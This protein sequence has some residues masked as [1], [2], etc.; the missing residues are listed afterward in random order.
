MSRVHVLLLL[1]CVVLPLSGAAQAPSPPPMVPAP[2]APPAEAVQP[3]GELIPRSSVTPDSGRGRAGRVILGPLTG[4]VLG[5]LAA[6]PGLVL[7]GDSFSCSTCAN[8]SE[9]IGGGLVSLVGFTAGTALGVKLIGSLFWG[10]GRFLKTLLGSALGFGGGLLTMIPLIETEGGWAVPLIIGPL[11]GA[12][13]GYELSHTEEL[14]RMAAGPS[15]AVLPS[16]SV[17][18]SGGVIAGLMGRF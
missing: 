15:V 12:V 3:E 17:H 11:I 2:A 6:T 13:I 10:E 5:L 14:E 7:M 9:I 1:L 16:V 4:L 18:P 8:D